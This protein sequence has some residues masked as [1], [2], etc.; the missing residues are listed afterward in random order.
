MYSSNN[1]HKLATKSA[2]YTSQSA[3]PCNIANQT[4]NISLQTKQARYWVWVTSYSP[5]PPPKQALIFSGHCSG[6]FIG[7]LRFNGAY[8][9]S[10]RLPC[11]AKSE[12]SKTNLKLA[13]L[14]SFG[15][16]LAWRRLSMVV[17][18]GCQPMWGLDYSGDWLGLH[19]HEGH[20]LLGPFGCTDATDRAL[21][22]LQLVYPCPVID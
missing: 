10:I 17:R 7:P 14:V 12:N 6:S 4:S 1:L 8:W 22:I 11:N 18:P 20:R 3:D 13:T 15:H 2:T 16:S 9:A 19:Q 21:W 5:N